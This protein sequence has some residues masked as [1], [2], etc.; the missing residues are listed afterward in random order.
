MV[1]NKEGAYNVG[2]DY[3]RY[4][5]TT[6]VFYYSGISLVVFCFI[7]SYIFLSFTIVYYFYI[8]MVVIIIYFI[9]SNQLGKYQVKDMNVYIE[10]LIEELLNLWNGI[11]MF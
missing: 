5:T 9:C 8:L 10:P 2:N 6:I 1:V 4:V 7:M 11:T 3:S